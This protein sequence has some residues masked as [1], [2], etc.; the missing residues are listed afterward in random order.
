MKKKILEN[1]NA[2]FTPKNSGE[3]LLIHNFESYLSTLL[4]RLLLT[5]EDI[6]ND[7]KIKIDKCESML[8]KCA[9]A[10]ARD[11]LINLQREKLEGK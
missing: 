9:M 8:G 10:D 1:F 5:E 6:R 3:L 11:Y 7:Y 2:N 4:D